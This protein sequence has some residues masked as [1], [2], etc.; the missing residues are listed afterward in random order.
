MAEG[1]AE[2]G[3]LSGYETNRASPSVQRWE[4]CAK[5]GTGAG[6]AISKVESERYVKI[7]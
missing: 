1:A 5:L 7:T 2:W 6:M 3:W 4:R